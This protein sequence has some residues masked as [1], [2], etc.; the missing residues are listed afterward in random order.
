MYHYYENK[1]IVAKN[2][3][4]VQNVIHLINLSLRKYA[5]FQRSEL[6]HARNLKEKVDQSHDSLLIISLKFSYLRPHNIIPYDI[7]EQVFYVTELR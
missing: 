7:F 4:V 5:Y 6:V 1:W 2:K 3:K